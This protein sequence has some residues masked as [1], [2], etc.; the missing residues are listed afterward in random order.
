MMYGA[1]N[2]KQED[3]PVMYSISFHR[4]SVR[5]V[6]TIFLIRITYLNLKKNPVFLLYGC[7]TWTVVLKKEHRLFFG[8]GCGRGGGI[9]EYKEQWNREELL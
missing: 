2:V 8:T 7:E 5:I 4:S 6:G 1:Y 9:F 3:I